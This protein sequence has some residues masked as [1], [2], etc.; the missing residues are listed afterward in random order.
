MRDV[1]LIDLSVKESLVAQLPSWGSPLAETV[2]GALIW[3][4]E[5]AN[6]KYVV[7]GFDAFN[8]ETSRFALLIPSAPILLSRCLEWLAV[9]NTTVQPDVAKVGTPVKILLSDPEAEDD[10]TVQL[11]DGLVTAVSSGATPIIFADTSLVGLYS[12][13]VN[14][15][16]VGRFAVNLLD[17]QESGISSPQLV[18]DGAESGPAGTP[19]AD[20][21]QEVNREIWKFTACLGVLLL[22]IEWWVY[23]RNR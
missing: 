18:V 12:V 16:Q 1:S 11:P 6:R 22:L 2:E 7:F 14:N 5:N 19:P 20:H 17:S 8:L 15:R 10:V 9:P 13:S 23:H 21:L 4:G 3:A